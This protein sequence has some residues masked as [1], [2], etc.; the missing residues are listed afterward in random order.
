[1]GGTGVEEVQAEASRR[2]EQAEGG[3]ASGAGST[4]IGNGCAH[5]IGGKL[6]RATTR[7]DLGVDGGGWGGRWR[8]HPSLMRSIHSHRASPDAADCTQGAR[9]D[10]ASLNLFHS[11]TFSQGTPSV[12]AHLVERV[13]LD[14][15][16]SREQALPHLP[17]FLLAHP[18]FRPGDV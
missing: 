16:P 10:A 9:L 2:Q 17:R 18:S 3:P 4:I 13:D 7:A 12:C 6:I 14:L 15:V 11:C 5:P 8:G 1:M